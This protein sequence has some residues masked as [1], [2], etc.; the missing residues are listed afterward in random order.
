MSSIG[1]AKSAIK[2]SDA[3]RNAGLGRDASNSV[4][5]SLHGG[6]TYGLQVY[7]TARIDHLAAEG[8]IHHNKD[9]DC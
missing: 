4:A 6:L 8:M 7:G 5:E 2:V 3:E 9:F 1:G